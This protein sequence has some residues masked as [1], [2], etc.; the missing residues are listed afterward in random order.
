ML[1]VRVPRAMRDCMAIVLL[2]TTLFGTGLFVVALMFMLSPI[3]RLS[4]P[5]WYMIDNTLWG[6]MWAILV[7]YTEVFGGLRLVFSGDTPVIG[8]SMLVISNHVSELDFIVILALAARMDGTLPAVRFIAKAALAKLPILG[9]GLYLHHTIFIRSRPEGRAQHTSAAERV[10][11]VALD[12]E[13]LTETARTLTTEHDHAPVTLSLFPEGTRITSA[14]HAKAVAHAGDKGLA[15]LR[16]LLLPRAKGLAAVL[17]GVRSKMTHALDLTL[18]Y[19]GLS[20][21]CERNERAAS[22][23]DGVRRHPGQCV[24]VLIR[25]IQLPDSGE[26]VDSWIHQRWIEKE[27]DLE[28]WEE[29]GQFDAEPMEMPLPPSWPLV[30]AALASVAWAVVLGWLLWSRTCLLLALLLDVEAPS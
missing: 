17:E 5:W 6:P 4:P 13:N 12:I 18:A 22:I 9:Q 14:Q 15:P 26:N 21:E 30:V 29:S 24:H 28:R 19:E 7:L 25:R 11:T 23:L 8:E 3:N 20:A 1:C 27:R 2:V 16:F 10:K